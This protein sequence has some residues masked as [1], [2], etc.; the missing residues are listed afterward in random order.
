MLR[1]S[2]FAV[3]A[4][5]LSSAPVRAQVCAGFPSFQSRPIQVAGGAGFNKSSK[6]FGVAVAGGGAR[7]FVDV[8]LGTTHIDAYNASALNVGVE[9]GYQISLGKKGLLQL[10]PGAGLGLLT[11]P[12]NILG[13][14]FDYSETDIRF[15]VI[16]GGVAARGAQVDVVPTGLI[17]FVNAD[18][19][20]QDAFGS[21]TSKSQSFGIVGLG[22]G[23]VLNHELSIRPSVSIPFGH[24]GGPTSFGVW[25]AVNFR[26]T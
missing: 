8:A 26:G 10:C 6:S 3:L 21:S 20:F 19:K 22:L 9:A 2:W 23:V 4:T 1:A 25:L 24:S 7:A 11:G 18:G 14:G 13:T 12:K 17:E 15:G 5:V 16:V